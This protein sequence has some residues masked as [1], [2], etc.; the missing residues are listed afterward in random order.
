MYTYIHIVGINVVPCLSIFVRV[1]REF[2]STVII[3]E[4][5]SRRLFVVFFVFFYK[6]MYI[7]YISMDE[8]YTGQDIKVSV[9]ALIVWVDGAVRSDADVRRTALNLLE[10]TFQA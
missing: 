8:W 4:Y 3:W 10:E 1:L 5:K 7:S 6:C 2:N 9:L